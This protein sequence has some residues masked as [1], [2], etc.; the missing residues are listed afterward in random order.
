VIGVSRRAVASLCLGATAL[1]LDPAP[2]RAQPAPDLALVDPGFDASRA[3]LLRAIFATEVFQA[4]LV[5]DVPPPAAGPPGLFA[6]DRS[7][8]IETKTAYAAVSRARLSEAERAA[9]VSG[10]M[11]ITLFDDSPVGRRQTPVSSGV[12]VMHQMT[13]WL[14]LVSDLGTTPLADMLT[15]QPDPVARFL[16]VLGQVEG[17]CA[18]AAEYGSL[19]SEIACAMTVWLVLHGDDLRAMLADPSSDVAIGRPPPPFFL[20][21]QE[22]CRAALRDLGIATEGLRLTAAGLRRPPT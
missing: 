7:I 12:N 9:W 8:A 18:A 1:A 20:A 11:T 4:S 2:V 15:P 6:P 3:T 16:A 22:R 14:L 13:R 17:G 21:L 10:G 19:T 5:R